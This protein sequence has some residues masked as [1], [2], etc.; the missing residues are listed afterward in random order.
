LQVARAR[1]ADLIVMGAGR[2]HL[3]T[4]LPQTAAYTVAAGSSCP[5]LTVRA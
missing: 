5:V 1:K 2:K 4:H 3:V